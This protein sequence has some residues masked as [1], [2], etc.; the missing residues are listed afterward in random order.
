MFSVVVCSRSLPTADARSVS[1][2]SQFLL[3]CLLRGT[4]SHRVE[5][6]YT[7]VRDNPHRVALETIMFS[8][9]VVCSRSLPTADARPVSG[10]SQFLLNCLSRGTASHRVEL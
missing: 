2:S 5:L 10:S 4:A 7:G 3:R 9:V 8:T 6:F 1:G